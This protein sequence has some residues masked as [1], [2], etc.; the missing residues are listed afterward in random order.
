MPPS[1][2]GQPQRP[3]AWGPPSISENVHQTMC[4]YRLG[5]SPATHT[6]CS[7]AQLGPLWGQLRAVHWQLRATGGHR[8]LWCEPQ[9]LGPKGSAT[10]VPPSAC[11]YTAPQ[12]PAS[13]GQ[14]D[15][16]PLGAQGGCPRPRHLGYSPYGP[17]ADFEARGQVLGHKL[18]VTALV[19]VHDV[20]TRETCFWVEGDTAHEGVE[21]T[22]PWAPW[23]TL[24]R[25]PLRRPRAPSAHLL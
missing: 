9:E 15:L 20:L 25:E 19:V 11:P 18:A 2:K 10:G 3:P 12:S 4:P 24:I 22:S 7:W 13:Q 14:G 16:T 6:S 23:R 17:D 8:G 1:Q 5:H 21:G